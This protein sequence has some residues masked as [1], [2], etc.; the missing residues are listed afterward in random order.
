MSSRAVPAYDLRLLRGVAT[1]GVLFI[2]STGG[3]CFDYAN[4]AEYVLRVLNFFPRFSLPLFVLISG[5]SLASAYGTR[6]NLGRFYQ[7]RAQAILPPY[8]AFSSF[9]LLFKY[10]CV[11]RGTPRAAAEFSPSS[12]LNTLLNGSA[13]YHLWFLSTLVVLYAMFPLFRHLLSR[14]SGLAAGQRL[15][16]V[17]LALQVAWSFLQAALGEPPIL[18]NVV[19]HILN[20]LIIQ[21]LYFYAGMH[22][23]VHQGYYR[24]LATEVSPWLFLSLLTAMPFIYMT[25]CPEPGFDTPLRTLQLACGAMLL[26]RWLPILERPGRFNTFLDYCAANSFALYLVH[27]LVLD[28]FVR[29]LAFRG[30][31]AHT[32]ALV[33]PTLL[34]TL[35]LT[36][37]AVAILRTLPGRRYLIGHD[38]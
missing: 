16:L 25:S 34:T 9:A 33:L 27:P 15:L 5:Y 29:L 12:L 24:R 11:W 22:L 37:L 32:P 38:R 19:P 14:C 2:H 3:R 23:A 10:S 8:L 6:G 1:L 26:L 36:L 4:V 13:F 20:V 21:G 31:N 17:W 28:G 18:G 35:G 7:R 30:L